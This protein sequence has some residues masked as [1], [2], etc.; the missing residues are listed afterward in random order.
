MNERMFLIITKQL[1]YG[2][3]QVEP[4]ICKKVICKKV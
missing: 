3:S 1:K 2:S 4:M